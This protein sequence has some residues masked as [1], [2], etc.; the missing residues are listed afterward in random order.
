MR[1]GA[2]LSP[3]LF[4]TYIDSIYD[5]LSASGYGCRIEN[6]YF[7]CFSYADDIALIAP[8]REALQ[9]MINTC[10]SYFTEHGI[11][12][13]TNQN[14]QKTKTKIL[15]F[16]IKE[17]PES[18]ILNGRPLPYVDSWYHL[19]HLIHTDESTSHDIDEKRREFIGKIHSFRQ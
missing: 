8:S 3:T 1:Q 2:V 19:G 13:S 17:H 15:V 18:I 11:E 4:N 12:I 10:S 16:G 7:G 6:T 5:I 14:P 9:K